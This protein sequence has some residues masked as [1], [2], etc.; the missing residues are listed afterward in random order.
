MREQRERE[1]RKRET[2]E[3]ER[4]DVR[5]ERTEKEGE[6]RGERLIKNPVVKKCFHSLLIE[7][8]I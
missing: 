5:G 1:Q 8:Q 6:R 4:G 2:S 3:R 7:E